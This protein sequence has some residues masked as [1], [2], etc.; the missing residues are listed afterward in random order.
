MQPILVVSP[1]DVPPKPIRDIY[2]M[3]AFTKAKRSK[4]KLKK[5]DHLVYVYGS[6]DPDDCYNFVSHEDFVTLEEGKSSGFDQIPPKIASK[7]ESERTSSETKLVRALEEM[8]AD[9]AKAPEDR[10]KHGTPF[11]EMHEKLQAKKGGNSKEEPP[12]KK[13]KT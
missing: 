5:L 6:D 12:T 1:Y 3:H 8:K 7:S 13:L 4:A 11:L 10:R 2:W 9:L